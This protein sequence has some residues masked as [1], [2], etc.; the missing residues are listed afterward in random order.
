MN[1][2]VGSRITRD[3]GRFVDGSDG[4]KVVKGIYR[5]LGIR[6]LIFMIRFWDFLFVWF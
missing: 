5:G 6:L 2:K 1:F 3:S 4:Y